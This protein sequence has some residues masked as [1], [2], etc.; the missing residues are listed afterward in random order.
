M[1]WV[2]TAP[3]PARTNGQDAPTAKALVAT[4]TAKAS[5]FGSWATMDQVM[6]RLRANDGQDS[7]NTA[8]QEAIR[9]PHAGGGRNSI[10]RLASAT[11]PL[12]SRSP[13]AHPFGCAPP[14]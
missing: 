3:T 4:A 5:V 13:T 11:P 8:V 7:A 14:D 10:I 9:E 2:E 6:R 1:D 12:R